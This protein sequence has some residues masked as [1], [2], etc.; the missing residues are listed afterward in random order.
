MEQFV[1]SA[2][3][4]RPATFDTV[5]G[6]EAVT[7]TLKNA[8]KSGHLAHAFLFTGPRG[9]GKTTCARILA[10]TINC[11]NRSE[12]V[13]ACGECLPCKTFEEGHSMNIFELDAAS[14]NSVDDIRN[15]NLQVQIAPQVG[16]KKVYIIDE[17]H[18]LSQ[19]AFNAFLKTLEEPPSYAIFILATTEKHKIL[20][21]ILSRCQV[22]DFRRIGIGDISKHLASI[23]AKEGIDAEPQA[24]HTIAQKAD[25]GLRDA[26][27]IF[28]QL[29]SFSGN[30]LT[31]QDVV[32]NLNVLDH[33]HYFRITDSLIRGDVPAVLV[34]YNHIL[35]Q[36]FDGHLFV[37]GLARHLRDLLI[38]QDKRTLPLLEVSEDLTARYAQQAQAADRDLLIKGL[39]KL[40]QCDTQYRNSKEPRLLVELTLIQLCRLGSNTPDAAANGSPALEKKSPDLTGKAEPVRS[41]TSIPQQKPASAPPVQPRLEPVAMVA[42]RPA[43]IANGPST[44]RREPLIAPTVQPTVADKTAYVP[45]RRLM[46]DQVSITQPVNIGKQETAEV[47]L[48][49]VEEEGPAASSREVNHALLVRAWED[50]A[51]QKKKE[52]KSSLY[53]TLTDREPKVA[54]VGRVSFSIVNDVQENY[55]KTEKPELLGHLRRALGDPGL[56]LEVI[57][58]EV[59]VR[60]RYTNRDR[61]ELLAEK[62]PALRALKDAVDLDLG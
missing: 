1:V 37:T 60:P 4:Y 40:A 18:M 53:A 49:D 20:P 47:Q 46:M 11:E 5:V 24:L 39:D 35:Q 13:V 6:Q 14:N 36:G 27:S 30:R 3:K 52:G 56:E 12:D 15:L 38:S 10:R 58:E 25:G 31:Y 17:V 43:P 54:G 44:Y 19:A 9:V 55:L 33:E 50:F 34:E 28:D 42:E 23:A 16:A 51:Q 26:L 32:K 2:R 41:E 7:S 61:F 8:I 22:F 21:T 45:K 48:A 62:N 57:K 59:K 29:V